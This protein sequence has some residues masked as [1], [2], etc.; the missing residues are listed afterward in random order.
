MEREPLAAIGFDVDTTV[1]ASKTS[2][3]ITTRAAR[4]A[5]VERG[6]ILQKLPPQTLENTSAQST[7]LAVAKSDVFERPQGLSRPISQ[8]ILPPR[9]SA[10]DFAQSRHHSCR[11]WTL[12]SAKFQTLPSFS[13]SAVEDF[14]IFA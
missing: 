12:L 8:S 13:T 7:D 4:C 6:K 2:S 1:Y 9:A 11:S 3:P 14:L 5:T 10:S